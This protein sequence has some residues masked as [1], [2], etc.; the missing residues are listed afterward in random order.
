MSNKQNFRT[1]AWTAVYAGMICGVITHL[2]GL[3][4]VLHNC[5]D[6]AQQP[7]GY[8][9]GITSG[10]WLLPLLGD[11][12]EFLGGNYN[13]PLVNGLVFIALLSLSAGLLVAI[14]DFKSKNLAALVGMLFVVFPPVFSTMTF[15]YTVIYYGIAIMCSVLAAYVMG[16]SRFDLLISGFLTACS[17]GIYQAYVPVTIAIFVMLLM[18]QAMEGKDTLKNLIHR[19][20]RYCAALA[21]GLILYL[22]FLKIGLRLSGE[23]LS[24]YRGIDQMGTASLMDLPRLLK[25]TIY[26]FCM[27]PLRDY[28]GLAATSLVKLVYLLLGAASTVLLAIILVKKVKKPLMIAFILLMC[29]LF[30]VAANFVVV[31]CSDSWLYT[32]MLFAM[33]MVPFL[34]VML[35]DYL[36]AEM[37]AAK[38][39]MIGVKFVGIVTAVL[40]CAYSYGTNVNYSAMYFA[41]RQ[42]ENYLNSMVVQVRMT[43][44]FD[45]QKKWAMIGKIQ[46]PLLRSWWQYEISYGGTEFTQ[47]LINRESWFEW[48]RNYYG[49]TFPMAEEAEI[50]AL[51]ETEEVRNMPCWPSEGSIKVIGDTVVIKCQESEALD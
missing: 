12:A 36:L 26:L 48:I 13:L 34:P 10:R 29:G 22:V 32:L 45:A 37:D 25:E 8:G 11:A 4:N 1:P 47:Y 49:Y 50:Q 18:R 5:D 27:M 39:K 15:R 40:I 51:S 46:D 9:T 44:G 7:T 20:I 19:G 6:I 43:E 30:P 42:V 23:G 35:A 28:C 38:W 2:F 41:S 14:F 3:V 31:M 17:L 33:V 24:D 21:L 16:K